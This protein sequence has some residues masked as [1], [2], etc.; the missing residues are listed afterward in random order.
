M[1]V[2]CSSAFKLNKRPLRNL[3]QNVSFEWICVKCHSTASMKPLFPKWEK[4]L[5]INKKNQINSVQFNSRLLWLSLNPSAAAAAHG[6]Q[7]L[8]SHC[9]TSLSRRSNNSQ[10]IGGFTEA[11]FC[12]MTATLLCHMTTRWL[13]GTEAFVSC[14]LF[15]FLFSFKGLKS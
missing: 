14:V 6:C 9:C 4:S 15:F 3:R 13:K 5:L 10:V 11:P 8:W 2:N 7:V 12:H 1:C